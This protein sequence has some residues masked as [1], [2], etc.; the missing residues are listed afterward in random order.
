MRGDDPAGGL[1]LQDPRMRIGKRNGSI[2]TLR[3]KDGWVLHGGEKG[4]R[5][6][7]A[8]ISCQAQ[9][10]VLGRPR[11]RLK[12]NNR[13][14]ASRSCFGIDNTFRRIVLSREF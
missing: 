11:S 4:T 8:I 2:D 6:K 14:L 9:N 12:C 5:F 10:G 7:D 1:A 3:F 13:L